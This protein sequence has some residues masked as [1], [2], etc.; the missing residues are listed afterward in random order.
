MK[1]ALYSEGGRRQKAPAVLRIFFIGA[2]NSGKNAN[3]L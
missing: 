2:K 1:G 3:F